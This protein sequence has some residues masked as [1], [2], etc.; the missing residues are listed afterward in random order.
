[1]NFYIKVTVWLFRKLDWLI[2][3]FYSGTYR[4]LVEQSLIIFI[5]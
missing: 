1:M 3:E 5:A 4:N 2:D